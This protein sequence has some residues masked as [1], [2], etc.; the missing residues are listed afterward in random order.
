ML[1]FGADSFVFQYAIKNLKIKIFRT[2]N[3]PVILSLTI[4]EQRRLRVFE[5]GMLRRIFGSKRDEVT[6]SGKDLM[7]NIT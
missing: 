3:L 2:K 7:T 6:K 4:K 5:K 1:S